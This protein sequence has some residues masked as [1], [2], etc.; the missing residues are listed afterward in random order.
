[1]VNVTKENFLEQS[2]KLLKQLNNA[3][4]CALDLEMTGIRESSDCPT[5]KPSKCDTPE[6]RY[7]KIRSVPERYGIIQIGLS[8]FLEN[9]E[10]PQNG[11]VAHNYNFYVF[12][13]SGGSS[14]GGKKSKASSSS[15]KDIVLS[16]SSIHFLAQHE[17]NFNYWINKGM[18]Y[19][20]VKE[21]SHLLQ[22]FFK[23]HQELDEKQITNLGKGKDRKLVLEPT[24]PD[25]IRFIARTMADLREWIDAA[26][27]TQ[28]QEGDADTE[29][30]NNPPH[31]MILP[32]CNAFLRKCLYDT[33]EFEYPSLLLEKVESFEKN[34]YPHHQQQI[35]VLRLDPT[36]KKKRLKHKKKLEWER[37]QKQEIGWTRIFRALSQA[38]H[39]HHQNNNTARQVPIVV[40]NGLMD[41]MFLLTHFHSQS[42]PKDYHELKSTIRNYFPLLYDSKVIATEHYN[43]NKMRNSNNADLSPFDYST[44]LGDLFNNLCGTNI[45]ET[46]DD[47][48]TVVH[49][50]INNNADDTVIDGSTITIVNIPIIEEDDLPQTHA[51]SHTSSTQPKLHEA[52]YD[53]YMTGCVFYALCGHIVSESNQLDIKNQSSHRCCSFLDFDNRLRR[54]LFGCNKIYLM[55][56]LYTMD[57]ETTYHGTNEE[58]EES[59]ELLLLPQDPL[60]RQMSYST[61]YCVSG[62]NFPIHT[63]DIARSLMNVADSCSAD[64]TTEE[65]TTVRR[66]SFEIIWVDDTTVLVATRC[67]PQRRDLLSRHGDLILTELKRRFTHQTIS[68]LQDFLL[69][70]KREQQLQI[71]PHILPM[72]ISDLSTT[73]NIDD[74]TPS[75]TPSIFNFFTNG[76]RHFLSNDRGSND[77]KRD[78]KEISHDDN[79]E[80]QNGSSNKRQRVTTSTRAS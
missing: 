3:K 30:N 53:A 26:A 14:F 21:E 38:N 58:K 35:R 22:Q 17:M 52:A 18:P 23:R 78:N 20:T 49:N 12:P 66:V 16:P 5:K 34:S 8:L 40:H 62:I 41:L 69:K 79:S 57:L 9:E 56:T 68:S 70:K 63:R 61:T 28:Q 6:E 37:L 71:N 45:N 32:P 1:M 47:S 15:T 31:S 54:K 33:I 50:N 60:N 11:L 64:E 2:D 59:E 39:G 25:D 4:F 13:S 77:K 76:L 80:I 7:D 73:D 65:T 55:Q 72:I 75:N 43:F 44:V 42:L 46:T 48:S 24:V 74:T 51:G 36:E 27:P 67:P 19:V 10:S 29:S